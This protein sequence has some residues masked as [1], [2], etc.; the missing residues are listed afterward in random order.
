MF[1]FI[2]QTESH[3]VKMKYVKNLDD[4]VVFPKITQE[5]FY[6]SVNMILE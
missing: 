2:W 3:G 5:C 6:F 4:E 1:A